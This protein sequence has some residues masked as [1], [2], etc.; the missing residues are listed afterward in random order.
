MKKE[1]RLQK[2]RRISLKTMVAFFVS[3]LLCSVLIVLSVK[4]RME[5]EE[6]VMEQ[7]IMEK[8]GSVNEVIT[9]LLYKT[10]ILSAFVVQNEGKIEEFDKI[11]APIVDDPAI[12]NVLIAPDG[13]VSH[14]YPLE[15]NEAV[16]N[17]DLLKE[18]QISGNLEAIKAWETGE[19]VFGG[20]FTLVQ[21]GQA[22]VGRLPVYVKDEDGIECFW[23]LASVTLKYPEVLKAANL[24]ILN[25]QGFTF[26]IWRINPD[27]NTRQVIAASDT[28][29]NPNNGYIEKHIPL[30]NADWYFRIA[31]IQSWYQNS[32]TWILIVVAICMSFLVAF[33]VQNN[34]ALRLM[35]SNLENMVLTDAMTGI[36]NRKGLFIEVDKLIQKERRFYLC[37]MDLNG[38]KKVNDTYG[39]NAGDLVLRE[40]TSRFKAYTGK[41]H[42]F[43]RIGGDEFV[44]VH[45]GDFS[46]S[47]EVK[48]FFQ[49]I[50]REFEKPVITPDGKSI[51]VSF[52][53]GIAQY[54]DNGNSIDELLSFAD[55]EMYQNKKTKG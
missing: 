34:S 36:L 44:L 29:M 25:L 55:K 4:S 12:L 41:C 35:K 53:R 31:S 8:A 27:D 7:L 16:V 48:N 45:V 3:L 47:E 38:F 13:I 39:H 40:F 20:P 9:K 10:Y 5:A 43:A 28:A 50:D 21:G 1:D 17:Y 33:V 14:V 24:E 42:V 6:A 11:A 26:E 30:M 52:S 46:S 19:L 51:Y 2:T 32:E 18:G 23:G 15:G 22:L 37:Y 49:N 54:P